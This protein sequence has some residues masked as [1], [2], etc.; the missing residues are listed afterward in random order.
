MATVLTEVLTRAC[1]HSMPRK[2]PFRKS[3]PWW[4]KDVTAMKRKVYRLK[5]E[6]QREIIP[7]GGGKDPADPKAYRPISLL[8]VIGKTFGKLMKMT[9][10]S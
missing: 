5:L 8:S 9:S 2:K 1:L 7:K 3:N 10:S 6:T 4:T